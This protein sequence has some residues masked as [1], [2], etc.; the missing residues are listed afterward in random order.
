[1]TVL[2]AIENADA[3]LPGTPAADGQVDPRW[4]AVIAVAEFIEDSPEP[5]WSF[6]ER[7]GQHADEDLRQAI[8]TCILEHLL[9]HHFDLVIPRVKRLARTSS[10]FAQ[11]LAMC[12][13]FGESNRPENAARLDRLLRH[14]RGVR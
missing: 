8:A 10:A 9:E 11:T 7:W 2:E 6:L 14:L 5:V 12:W 1:V 13:R 3:I 4:Q